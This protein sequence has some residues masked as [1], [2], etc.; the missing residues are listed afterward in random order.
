MML[1]GMIEKCRLVVLL[2]SVLLLTNSC[3]QKERR[4]EAYGKDADKVEQGHYDAQTGKVV[5]LTV[6]DFRQRIF[7]YTSQGDWAF[8]GS[9][10][11]IVDFYAT[12]CGPCKRT[13]PILAGIAAKYKGKIDVY[14]VDIDKQE[15]LARVFGITSIPALLF[16]PLTGQ[17]QMS[18]GAMEKEDME[19][20]VNEIL[21]TSVGTDTTE[22][23]N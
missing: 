15:E 21:F 13:A 14:K 10:P 3:R 19:R 12:W 1:F 6:A 20:C 7:D 17:P 11:A 4:I 9:R 23:H 16:I 18:V 22:I 5:E 8:L 2:F